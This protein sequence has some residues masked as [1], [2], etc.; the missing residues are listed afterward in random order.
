MAEGFPI[1]GLGA[2]LASGVGAFAQALDQARKGQLEKQAEEEKFGRELMMRLAEREAITGGQIEVEKVKTGFTKDIE[3]FKLEGREKLEKLKQSGALSRVSLAQAR[4]GYKDILSNLTDMR[5]HLAAGNRAAASR[6]A[7]LT[8][9]LISQ[10]VFL[11]DKTR[12]KL[13]KQIEKISTPAVSTKTLSSFDELIRK[14]RKEEAD[15]IRNA[16]GGGGLQ[17]PSQTPELSPEIPVNPQVNQELMDYLMN[18]PQ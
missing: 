6:R 10:Y 16:L 15:L 3:K 13:L 11:E 8:S 5:Q 4:S 18:P 17:V 9:T 7:T 12:A 1:T 2:G 14:Y